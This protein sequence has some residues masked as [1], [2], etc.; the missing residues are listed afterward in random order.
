MNGLEILKIILVLS[1]PLGFLLAVIINL[2]CFE[3]DW[4][5]RNKGGY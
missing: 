1:L 4:K 2:A 3:A 5:Q